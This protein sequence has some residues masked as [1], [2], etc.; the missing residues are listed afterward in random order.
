MAMNLRQCVLSM[1]LVV[2]LIHS[3]VAVPPA[4][5][6]TTLAPRPLLH[7]RSAASPSLQAN[8]RQPWVSR[9]PAGLHEGRQQQPTTREES[10]AQGW[11]RR[12]EAM[13]KHAFI[14][15]AA[16]PL[17][18]LISLTP[19]IPA[20]A[21]TPEAPP[22]SPA[23]V[24]QLSLPS[25]MVQEQPVRLD[26]GG[27]PFAVA[28]STLAKHPDTV[29]GQLA[30]QLG[31]SKRDQP[32]FIDADPAY[33][34]YVVDYYRFGAPIYVD[35]SVDIRK[36]VRELSLVGIAIDEVRDIQLPKQEALQ[37]LA[38]RVAEELYADM[39]LRPRELRIFDESGLKIKSQY[40]SF[41]SSLTVPGTGAYLDSIKSDGQD[42]ESFL[43]LVDE[44]TRR[45]RVATGSANFVRPFI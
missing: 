20:L 15:C 28:R 27:Q 37:A 45:T 25:L 19:A 39:N 33:F 9:L 17:I 34:P 2:L 1:V 22:P 13:L 44:R 30:S 5:C 23:V 31:T 18:A 10:G 3:L 24:Q 36:L 8:T 14:S 32:V 42:R 35:R 38:D 26:V 29:L 6:W 7:G 4:L 16:L 21:G 41:V 11:P 43:M 40:D 12:M